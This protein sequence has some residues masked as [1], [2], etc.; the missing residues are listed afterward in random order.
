M[1]LLIFNWP[2]INTN[3]HNF[4]RRDPDEIAV[5]SHGAS[6]CAKGKLTTNGHGLTRVFRHGLTQIYTDFFLPQ[7]TPRRYAKV[8]PAADKSV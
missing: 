4:C 8:P 6:C 1:I 5:A 2:R 7:S 3:K